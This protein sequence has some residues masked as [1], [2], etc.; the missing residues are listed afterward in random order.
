MALTG[1]LS[2]AAGLTI[3]GGDIQS[4]GKLTITGSGTST[5]PNTNISTLGNIASLF[6]SNS[7]TSTIIDANQL[8]KGSLEVKNGLVL[9]GDLISTGTF[10]F[11]GGGTSTVSNFSATNINTTSLTLSGT[12]EVTTAGT[13]T[14]AGGIIATSLTLSEGLRVDVGD[15]IF[16]QKIT[17]GAGTSTFAGDINANLLHSDTQLVLAGLPDCNTLDTDANGVVKCGTDADTGATSG[18]TD[19]G[20]IVRLQTATDLVELS[21]LYVTGSD[22][23][24][25]NGLQATTTIHGEYGYLGFGSTT[26]FGQVSVEAVQG[27]VGSNTPIFVVGDQGTNSPIIYVTGDDGGVGI[28]TDNAPGG[29]EL[30]I[31]AGDGTADVAQFDVGTNGSLTLSTNNAS[32]NIIVNPAG[33]LTLGQGG[34]DAIAIGRT[35]GNIAV[36][37]RGTWTSQ[38]VTDSATMFRILNAAGAVVLNVDT[39]SSRVGI[40]RSSP[41]TALEVVG[42]TTTTGIDILGRQLYIGNGLQATSS[43][44]GQ[45][46]NLGFASTVPYGQFSIESDEDVVGSNTPI[47]VVGDQGTATPIIYVSGA[48]GGVGFFTDAP[49]T[50]QAVTV[51]SQLQVQDTNILAFGASDGGY[52][53]V[54]S[55][56]A[57]AGDLV[58]KTYVS[59]SFLERFRIQNDGDIGVGTDTPGQKLSVAGGG[60]FKGNLGIEATSTAS[61]FNATSTLS[62]ASSSPSTPFAVVG[63]SVFGGD[64][65]ITGNLEVQGGV[66]LSGSGTTTVNGLTSI[67]GLAATAGGLVVSGGQ[68][69]F[70]EGVGIGTANPSDT[71]LLHIAS[72]ASLR[73]KIENTSTGIAGIE[74]TANATSWFIDHRGAEAPSDRLTIFD[75]GV[76]E[77]L[78]IL[79]G[80]NVGINDGNPGVALEVVGTTS[81]SNGINIYGSQLFIGNGKTAT[82]SIFGQYGLLG[83]GTATPYGQVSIEA[84]QGVAGSNTPIFVVGDQG[85][86]SP[87][88]YVSGVNGY[89]GFGTSSPWGQVSIEIL[90]TGDEELPSFIVGDE[91]SS[92]PALAVYSSGIT[93]IEQLQTGVMSFETNAGA[94]TWIDLPV[95]SAAIWGTIESYTAQVDA[96]STLTVYA[97][98][99]G[100]GG[101]FRERVGIGTTT[102]GGTFT[103]QSATSSQPAFYLYQGEETAEA[104]R[105]QLG[106]FTSALLLQGDGDLGLATASPGQ[107]LSV[108]GGGLFKGNLGIEAT[109]TASSFIATSTLSVGSS[110]PSSPFAVVGNSVFGGDVNITGVLDVQGSVNFAG[111]G[112]TT[113]NGVT[114]TNGLAATAGGLHVSGGETYLAEK[115]GIGTVSPTSHLEVFANASP[116][117]TASNVSG[118]PN[119]IAG[120]NLRID[121]TN[122]WQLITDNTAAATN[123][124]FLQYNDDATTGRFLTVSAT[125]GNFGLGDTNPEVR[126]EVVGTTSI[127]NGL[128]IYGKQ[129]FIGNGKSATSTL[130][131]QYGNLGFGSSSPYAQVSIESVEGITGSNTPIF[132]IGD[133]GSSSPVF[134]VSGRSTDAAPLI[135]IGTD[136]PAAKLTIQTTL[137]TAEEAMRFTNSDGNANSG[138]A[139]TFYDNANINAKIYAL[140]KGSNIGDLLLEAGSGVT[141]T[142]NA[143]QLYLAN[144]TNVGIGTDTPGTQFAIHGFGVAHGNFNIEATSTASSFI[145][146]STL[147]VGSSS[148]S[149]EF[150]VVGTSI[151]GGDV[152]ITG[153]LDVQGTVNFA[154]SG[155]TTFA[156]VTSTNGLA[157]TAGGLVVSGGESYF[158]ER[159]GIG[160]TGPLGLLHIQTP[161]RSTAFS[162]GAG[163]DNWHDII[164]NNPSSEANAAAGLAFVLGDYN[165]NA[166]VGIA[167][168]KSKTGDVSADL[169]IVTRPFQSGAL[170]RLRVTSDGSFGYATTSP[171]GQFAIESLQGVVGSNTPIFVVSDQGSS[172]PFIYVSGVNGYTGFGTSSPWGQVS[173]EILDTGDEELPS[174]VIA[175]EGTSTPS[176]AVY[177]SGATVI[178][179]L[180]TGIMSFETNAGAVAW[181]DLPVTSA[182][183]WGTVEGY[184]AQVDSTD[185]LTIYAE[186]DGKGGIINGRV[187]IGTTTPGGLLSVSHSSTSPA[188]LINQAAD[189]DSFN[190]GA[191]GVTTVSI[192]Q[193][194]KLA[195][196]TTTPGTGL[197]VATTSV[198][199]G[200]VAFTGTIDIQGT[201]TG[202]GSGT[203]GGSSGGVQFNNGG[204]F[205]ATS[206]LTVSSADTFVGGDLYVSGSD[207]FVGNGLQATT[208]IHGEYGQLGFGSTSPFGQVSIES[209]QGITG[210]NTP[211]FVVGDQGTATPFIYVS[212]NN[213]FVGI[214]TDNP[215]AELE[216]NSNSFWV[217][218]TTGNAA[219]QFR[220]AGAFLGYVGYIATNDTVTLTRDGT[221]I[222]GLHVDANYNV[223]IGT[224]VP[225]ATFAIHGFGLAHGNFNIEATSTASSFIATSTL[226]VGT[227]SP[228]TLSSALSVQGNAYIT[229]GL[230]VG[231]AT[232]SAGGLFVKGSADIYDGLLVRGR[233]GEA[234]PTFNAQGGGVAIGRP[235]AGVGDI[236]ASDPNG[237]PTLTIFGRNTGNRGGM[238]E[239]GS[240]GNGVGSGNLLGGIE[241]IRAATADAG[242]DS[243]ARIVGYV[244]SAGTDAGQI[245]F[246]TQAT[247]GSATERVVISP[248]GQLGIGDINPS[249]ALEVVGTTTITG[250][251]DIFGRQIYIGNGLVATSTI[252]GEYGK[253]GFGTTT[254]WGQISIEAVQGVVGSN[255]PIFVIGDSSTTTVTNPLFIVSGVNGYIGIGTSTPTERFTIASSTILAV[256]GEPKPISGVDFNS[257]SGV[258][259]FVIV[260]RYA[261]VVRRSASGGDCAGQSLEG[262]ELSIYDI[263]NVA[264]TTAIGGADDSGGTAANK[265]FVSGKYAYVVKV[266]DDLNNCEGAFDG[267]NGCEL[268]IYDISDPTAP[269]AVAA[270]NRAEGFQDVVA[271]GKYIYVVSDKNNTTCSATTFGGCEF[272]TYEW[273][274][275]SVPY[276]IGGTELGEV[277]GTGLSIVGNRAYVTKNAKTGT[278]DSTNLTGCEFAIYN[279]SNPASTTQIA[280]IDL[281]PN[282]IRNP[283]MVDKYAYVTQETNS[284]TCSGTTVVGCELI[285]LNTS[286][287]SVSALSG[288]SIGGTAGTSS[289]QVAGQY[290]YVASVNS[291]GSCSG[292][293][294]TGCEVAIVDVSN[295]FNAKPVA[296]INRDIRTFKAWP[297]GKYLYTGAQANTGI[298]GD[299]L[300]HCEL[301]VYD[302]GGVE[303]GS[304]RLGSLDVGNQNVQN[305]SDVQGKLTVNGDAQF[306]GNVTFT[307]STTVTEIT[308]APFDIASSTPAKNTLYANNI[309]KGWLMYDQVTATAAI[310]N[311]FNVSSVT[312]TTTGDFTVT[313]AQPFS[314]GYY[315]VALGGWGTAAADCIMEMY[316]QSQSPITPSSVRIQ[317]KTMTNS[318]AD[319][320]GATVTATG[321]Q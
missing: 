107:K 238:I 286:T 40:A 259:D 212:G 170:E 49:L 99:D 27:I 128:N 37:H 273:S 132:V 136:N 103:I 149:S 156:G 239:L 8:I 41:T 187:G 172:S 153:G 298:C 78:T 195:L 307:A 30:A 292:S 162:A 161:T 19:T 135:G 108:G 127:T 4:V 232:S 87:F 21:D 192:K 61:S 222:E 236:Y 140:H 179:N 279:I 85:S 282:T 63:E 16:D 216:I 265:I 114:S 102:P 110:S 111:A 201:C 20:T 290:A 233:N 6:V 296:G 189:G 281:S 96:T 24:V 207:L 257:T 228:A 82:S 126:L 188:V 117:I 23:F 181:V 121:T 124:F 255:T 213:G 151:F 271:V 131:G 262:C 13:S 60:L 101:V 227:T 150:A 206:A 1:G 95:T 94:I 194:G 304:A 208:T 83:F 319:C 215:S 57:V 39:S 51:N 254:P 56:A 142:T 9:G 174:F 288:V 65:T 243:V 3:S 53:Q 123:A 77:R 28:F 267:P 280:G 115:V 252:H 158:T 185:I 109:S 59:P 152:N 25:G 44:Y 141:D 180:Q 86:S 139:I 308:F 122:L 256:P 159:V 214:G 242:Y 68:S 38:P 31:G 71:N 118:A 79:N 229:Q 186:S 169:A 277:N 70:T 303:T 260:G 183:I 62:V 36:T 237:Y 309:V 211:I 45:Y 34:T 48:N 210:S 226:S 7:G 55:S 311:A 184:S 219:M 81:V 11:T 66:N 295:P 113:F 251:I 293:T 14:F 320:N 129:L 146:T 163:A 167:A 314:T 46:G 137:N 285:I 74:L 76:V 266:L 47:F 5:L 90:D 106:D 318:A 217:N 43:I 190:V 269:V 125:T 299:N 171:F 234:S 112:T 29:V 100:K 250:G 144:N 200:D 98:S 84:V 275:S 245:G 274:T 301:A 116:Q 258:Q 154:G 268:V 42:T 230:G 300:N 218:P 10:D 15:A 283:Y 91:G 35:D 92:T 17:V 177:S 205:G 221:A 241:F 145:A 67:N 143:N 138:S 89:T 240:H 287:S 182:A 97:E 72:S 52:I 176:F 80:G 33:S 291:S 202:C 264:S 88:I 18:W 289:V 209:V 175:D 54:N 2:S 133:S 93:T 64:V 284:G 168:V 272:L 315:A 231:V 173:V 263:S 196:G 155:T 305:N 197:S 321:L 294:L 157:A 191:R 198:F 58:F 26:P 313:W 199:S 270:A 225:G 276:V 32:G 12:L 147:S 312:D 73:T 204:S 148:P 104:I 22:I 203:P 50:T 166:G 261:Y 306:N 246:F 193:G 120:Y 253:L 119:G 248:T 220:N 224:T 178:E 244:T 223:G 164:I 69:Y 75:P 297:V 105:V 160:L 302:L 310:R 247:G 249:T 317:T 316:P 165:S 134:Y 278:C 130:Y 235:N